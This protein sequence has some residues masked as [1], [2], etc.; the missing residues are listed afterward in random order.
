MNIPHIIRLT[1]FFSV[2]FLM[3]GCG[4]DSGFEGDLE[5]V[6]LEGVWEITYAVRNGQPTSTLD[7]AEFV[8][9]NN[10][11]SS[12]VPGFAEDV[13]QDYVVS[14]DSIYTGASFPEYFLIRSFFDDRMELI[15]VV[16][17]HSFV[18]EIKRSPN[19]GEELN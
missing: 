19:S 1:T 8:F 10:R 17:G 9:M 16:H 14:Q 13:Q 4:T 7:G 6:E 3:V 11:F 2:L 5:K 18:F 12:N 15:T